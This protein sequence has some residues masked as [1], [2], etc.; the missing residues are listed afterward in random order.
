[1]TN[2]LTRYHFLKNVISSVV[3]FHKIIGCLIGI[4]LVSCGSKYEN[5]CNFCTSSS[6]ALADY[7]SYCNKIAEANDITI[8]D[9]IALVKEWKA[10]DDTISR[11]FFDNAYTDNACANDSIYVSLREKIIEGFAGLVDTRQRS[12]SDYVAVMDA[13]AERSQDSMTIAIQHFYESMDKTAAYGLGDAAT[14]VRYEQVLTKA[15][16]NGFRTRQDLFTFLRNE[17]VA[18]RSFLSHLNT[19][20][21]ISLVKVRDKTAEA[22]KHI[23]ELADG[24]SKVFEPTE[25]VPIITMRNNRRLIQNA[26]QCCTDIAS[27]KVGKG[28]Q[29][30]AYMWMLMQPWISF[31]AY[32]YTLMTQDQRK[33]MHELADKTA[34]CIVRLGSPE[35]PISP[36]ELPA[37]LIKTYITTL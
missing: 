18:F 26:Q 29:T 20:G 30:T 12:F 21:N 32:S 10:M 1:M 33:T 9:F 6:D 14:V 31:D 37:L 2:N 7:E 4:I 8:S 5:E 24:R 27:G 28:D 35:F 3:Y 25:L 16:A 34:D 13:L 36:N 17:D 22:M 11:K 15:N 23:I 19:L